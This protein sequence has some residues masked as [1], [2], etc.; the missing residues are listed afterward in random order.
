MLLVYLK[1][2]GSENQKKP[3]SSLP[4]QRRDGTSCLLI[5]DLVVVPK[6]TFLLVVSG[7]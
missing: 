4:S 2:N 6:C 7:Q 1:E 3:L 5:L